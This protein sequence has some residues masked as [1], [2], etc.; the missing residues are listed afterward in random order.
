MDRLETR[1]LA[2]FVAVAE[3]LHFGRAAERVG[4]A[5]PPLSR[6]IQQLERR[7]G[8]RLLERSSRRVT[9]TP[10][11]E[12]LLEESRHVLD[13]VAAAVARTR[14]AASPDRCLVLVLKPGSDGGLLPDVLSAY[15]A[16]PD[17]VTVD[18]Q[19]CGLGEQVGLLRRGAADVTF[20]H[21]VPA[22]PGT[23]QG[24]EPGTAPDGGFG[25]GLGD[26]LDSEVLL[27]E[28]QV[29]VLPPAHPLAA[30]ADVTLAELA[31]QEL[32]FWPPGL[33]ARRGGS[34][35]VRPPLPTRDPGR[36]LQLIALGRAV[37][38]VPASVGG[39]LRRDLVCV[40]VPDAPPS[41]VLIA[42]RGADRSRDVAA[43]VRTAAAV[44]AS[45]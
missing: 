28:P 27:A 39:Q 25:D 5:Q 2:C 12:V 38:V 3:E 1:E 41:R 17:A 45:R 14:R 40:P 15:A 42:W 29:A 9:L 20:L 32:P 35:V 24:T 8:V 23:D 4:V 36:L 31:A 21:D 43:F 18:L 30:R 44:A 22:P 16:R 10:A 7:L 26:D 33:V 11:G 19:F 37:A 34:G 13:A 6:T